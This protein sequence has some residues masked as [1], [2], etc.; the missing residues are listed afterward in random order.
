MIMGTALMYATLIVLA[1]I[2]VDISYGV[3]DPRIRN[4]G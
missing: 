3:L 2:M 4:Q 1:N